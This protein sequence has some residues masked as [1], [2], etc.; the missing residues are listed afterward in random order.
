[1]SGGQLTCLLHSLKIPRTTGANDDRPHDPLGHSRG[2]QY[3]QKELGG[4]PPQRQWHARRRRQPRSGQGADPAKAQAFIDE[5]QSHV[6]F[7]QP[8]RACTYDELLRASDIDAVYIPLPTG[9]RKEWVLRAAK[10]GK[11][12][13]CEKPCAPNAAEVKEMIDAC[14]QHN[15]QFMDGV[16]F[17]HS[18]RLPKM[19][20][21]LDDGTSVGQIKRI[22]SQFS[23]FGGEEFHKANIRVS[24]ALEPLGALGD[25]GWYNIRFTLWAMKYQVPERVSG[26]TLT[27]TS[28]GVPLEFSGELFFPGGVSASFYCSFQ[29]ENQQWANLSGDKG[30]LFL[31]DFVLSFYGAEAAFE[32]NR[33]IFE[34]M[35]CQYNMTAHTRRIAVRE[36]SNNAPTAQETQLFRNFA[37]LVL[38][39]KLDPH[40]P[41]I[42]LKTQQVV[43]ACMRSAK[44][45]GKLVEV[46]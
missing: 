32:V 2:R 3:R 44:Q 35:G 5:C 1:L 27:A 28:E 14:R 39:K 17:M 12:V 43:D 21:A 13:L 9:I 11:H 42:A 24:Q 40:W 34:P 26:R 10:A 29:T 19:R 45:G 15:V 31:P 30:F 18:G 23:F 6:S 4:H 46:K 37:Q 25:L 38:D 7:P 41:D 33:T 36:Y 16:M 8:P 20:E 22:A